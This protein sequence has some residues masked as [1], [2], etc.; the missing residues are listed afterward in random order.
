M[1]QKYYQNILSVEFFSSQLIYLFCYYRCLY[2]KF[3][4]EQKNKQISKLVE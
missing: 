1:Y 2:V 4:L 3:Y